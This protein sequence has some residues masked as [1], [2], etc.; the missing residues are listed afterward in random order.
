MLSELTDWTEEEKATVM[1]RFGKKTKYF[2]TQDVKLYE[3]SRMM[4]LLYQQQMDVL[5][6]IDDME[7]GITNK[8]RV[9]K[10]R[11]I[12]KDFTKGVWDYELEKLGHF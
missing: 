12:P 9:R 2:E 5:D 8:K 11:K 7:E 10:E 6:K 3:I 4:A 1:R